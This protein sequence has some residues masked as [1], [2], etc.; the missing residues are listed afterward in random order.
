MIAFL[1]REDE[2]AEDEENRANRERTNVIS[3]AVRESW[4]TRDEQLRHPRMRV[5]RS[6]IQRRLRLRRETGIF[7]NPEKGVTSTT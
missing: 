1:F 6:R 2:E 5:N 7:C 4:T 3:D